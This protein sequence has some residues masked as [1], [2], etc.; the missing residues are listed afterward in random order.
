MLCFVEFN[1][2]VLEHEQM[3]QLQ[4]FS[5][6]CMGVLESTDNNDTEQEGISKVREHSTV[7]KEAQLC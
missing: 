4:A 6:Q 3:L 5:E 7:E 2:P 1:S